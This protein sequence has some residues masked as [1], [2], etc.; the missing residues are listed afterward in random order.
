MA[1]AGLLSYARR[2]WRK[3][4]KRKSNAPPFLALNKVME[5]NPRKSRAKKTEEVVCKEKIELEDDSDVEILCA[6]LGYYS[7]VS[8][9][10]P[11]ACIGIRSYIYI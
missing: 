9:G 1:L 8:L 11:T 7:V 10:T 2:Y 5:K 4:L 6:P 3:G